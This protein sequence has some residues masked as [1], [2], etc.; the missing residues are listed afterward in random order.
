LVAPAGGGARLPD[1]NFRDQD[2]WAQ[3]VNAGMEV[4]S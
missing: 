1:F 2:F 4:S 3:G